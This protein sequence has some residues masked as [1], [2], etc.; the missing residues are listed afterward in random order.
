M[1]TTWA[2][3]RF[4]PLSLFAA[5][6]QGAW[7]DP[8]DFSVL[9]QDAAGITTVTAAGQPVGLILD[10]SKG[11]VRGPELVTNGDMSGGTTGWTA[12]N[13]VISPVA[14]KL[15]VDDSANAGSYSSAWQKISSNAAGKTFEITWTQTAVTGVEGSYV[16]LW[17]Q[18][19]NGAGTG[20]SAPLLTRPTNGTYTIRMTAINANLFLALVINGT[21]VMDFDDVS[22]REIFGSHAAQATA[23]ARPLLQR[24]AKD[25]RIH[26]DGVDDVLNTTFP[27]SLGSNCTVAHAVPN[28]GASI[29]TGQ[30]IGASYADNADHCG[31]IIINRA[32][33][34]G[35]TAKL[36]AWLNQRAGV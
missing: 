3:A 33:S 28:V 31:L 35:E 8:S 34:A 25:T 13:A 14:G 36:T 19:P 26:F 6:E 15:R 17:T 24:D 21:S 30:T 20:L 32:L 10:K 11:L 5:G 18:A 16:S 7:Y 1:L 22:V 12:L 27:A 4:S 23:A 29:L 9:F 2:G